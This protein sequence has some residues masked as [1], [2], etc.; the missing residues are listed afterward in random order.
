M[1]VGSHDRFEIIR[2]SCVA[3]LFKENGYIQD[4]GMLDASKCFQIATMTMCSSVIKAKHCPKIGSP[5]PGSLVSSF[6]AGLLELDQGKKVGF[7]K[8]SR[9]PPGNNLGPQ[10]LYLE[11]L[12][13]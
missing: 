11:A 9:R 8:G 6:M 4:V 13:A 1:S 7:G 10:G 2:F 12:V 5:I 3:I